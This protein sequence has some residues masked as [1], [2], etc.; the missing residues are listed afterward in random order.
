MMANEPWYSSGL[1]FTCMRCGRCCRRQGVVKL[2]PGELDEIAGY[3]GIPSLDY[4]RYFLT[5]SQGNTYLRDGSRGECIFLDW[6][7]GMCRVYPRRPDQCRR[8]PF[9]PSI[10]ESPSAWLKEG[11]FCPGIGTGELHSMEYIDKLLNKQ[12]RF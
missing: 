3:L 10:I 12:D 2:V 11:R 6:E 8:Y 1:F 5:D 7:S 4:V 9:W